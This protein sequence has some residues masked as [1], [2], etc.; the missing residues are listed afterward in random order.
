MMLCLLATPT[1]PSNITSISFPAGTIPAALAPKTTQTLPAIVNNYGLTYNSQVV[2][3]TDGSVTF[4]Y[5]T[6]AGTAG[7]PIG[8]VAS[9]TQWRILA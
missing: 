6:A 5:N 4:N 1:A 3:G 9:Q 7:Q 2:I 8:L